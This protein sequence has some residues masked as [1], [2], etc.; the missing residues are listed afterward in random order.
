MRDGAVAQAGMPLALLDDEDGPFAAMTAA[1]GRDAVRDLRDRARSA[2]VAA[3]VT[4]GGADAAAAADDD[5]VACG[6]SG[7]SPHF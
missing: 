3:H 2:L 4:A 6:C 1:L 7:F 5:D